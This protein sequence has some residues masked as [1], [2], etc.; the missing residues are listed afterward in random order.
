MNISIYYNAMY[1]SW[2]RFG[3][4]NTKLHVSQLFLVEMLLSD[5]PIDRKF[6]FS[7]VTDIGHD[8]NHYQKVIK[9]IKK[10][11]CTNQNCDLCHANYH[12][13]HS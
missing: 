13:L 7:L 1:C 11:L 12:P 5:W 9:K 4:C 6:K 8:F 10:K 2:F 3:C